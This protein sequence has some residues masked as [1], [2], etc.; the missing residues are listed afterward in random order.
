MTNVTPIRRP[1]DQDAAWA[2]VGVFTPQDQA[3]REILA[4]ELRD[5]A[6]CLVAG[7]LSIDDV[8]SNADPDALRALSDI[9]WKGIDR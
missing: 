3:A 8:Y 7:R 2:A 5:I 1:V 4:D 6:D 9:R